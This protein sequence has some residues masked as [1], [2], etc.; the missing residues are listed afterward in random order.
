MKIITLIG[1][2]IL[3]TSCAVRPSKFDMTNCALEKSQQY[4]VMLPHHYS[5][6]KAGVLNMGP[7]T[8]KQSCHKCHDNSLC[9]RCHYHGR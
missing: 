8:M 9:F 5:S 2:M 6:G 4:V 7:H 3:L 1:L